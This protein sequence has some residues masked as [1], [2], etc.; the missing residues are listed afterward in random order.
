MDRFGFTTA[1]ADATTPAPAGTGAGAPGGAAAA[2]ARQQAAWLENK[3]T[4]KWLAMYEGWPRWSQ[5]KQA[6]IKSRVRKGIP[7]AMRGKM[8]MVIS[9]ADALRDACDGTPR[10]FEALTQRAAGEFDTMERS[11]ARHLPGLAATHE[12]SLRQLELRAA[13]LGYGPNAGDDSP[14]PLVQP[15]AVAMRTRSL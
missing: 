4:L 12:E 1:T 6:K 9:G 15:R 10:S 3:R 8:W 2:R 11:S 7:D 5:R 13:I 14:L